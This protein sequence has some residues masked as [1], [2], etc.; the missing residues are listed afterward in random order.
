MTIKE[1]FSKI[2]AWLHLWLGIAS[3]IVVFII[4]MT[5]CILVFEQEIKGLMHANLKV[6]AQH[7]DQLLPPSVIHNAVSKAVPG[8]EITSMWYH[9]LDKTVAVSTNSDSTVFVNPY[10][11]EIVAFQDH[12]DF[13]HEVDELHRNLMLGRKIGKPVVGWSTFIFF[14]LLISGLILWWPKKWSKTNRDKSFKIKWKAK[15]KRINYD[16][17][18][19]LGFYT[20]L[21][22]LL[23]AI[24]GLVMSF[25]WFSRS[26]YWVTGGDGGPRKRP[27]KEIVA[28]SVQPALANADKIWYKIRKEIA[29]HNKNNVIVSIPE[30]PD[31]LIYA[32]TDMFAGYWRDLYFE[33]ATLELS[34]RS[35]KRL[36]DIPFADQVRKLNYSLHVGAALGL[37]SKIVYFICSLVCASLPVTGFYIWWGKKKKTKKKK[38]IATI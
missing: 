5:G 18:N 19:V 34:A 37:T 11:A 29:L 4:S 26:M 20:L 36:G 38:I 2:N 9:G 8:K 27:A 24:T 3:G 6:A 16:L 14:F 13:F 21:I 7:E 35:G 22:A 32:C 15:F 23:M 33:P 25:S 10:T 31:E 12:E 17:H 1:T 30:K 28:P